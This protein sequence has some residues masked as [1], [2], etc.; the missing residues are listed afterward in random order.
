MVG[1][2]TI[3]ELERAVRNARWQMLD[4]T[5]EQLQ[6]T[7]RLLNDALMAVKLETLS[8]TKEAK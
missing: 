3:K 4:F 7:D 6:N 8:R 1:Q 5:P 2:A